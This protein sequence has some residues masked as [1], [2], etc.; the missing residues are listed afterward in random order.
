MI[1]CG[2][3]VGPEGVLIEK[4]QDKVH[5]RPP[6][7]DSKESLNIT[8]LTQRELLV[9]PGTFSLAMNFIDPGC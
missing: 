4:E 6:A 8:W 5:H 7:S 2:R 9:S 1:K 3:R